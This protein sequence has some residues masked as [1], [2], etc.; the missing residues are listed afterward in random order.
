[1]LTSP[2]GY[3]VVVCRCPC[4]IS[5]H[6]KLPVAHQATRPSPG[7]GSCPNHPYLPSAALAGLHAATDAARPAM[8][9]ALSAGGVAWCGSGNARSSRAGAGWVVSLGGTRLCRCGKALHGAARMFISM[10]WHKCGV[11]SVHHEPCNWHMHQGLG[12]IACILLSSVAA[13][14]RW[15]LIDSIIDRAC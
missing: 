14:V 13:A 15:W 6:R 8:A 11:P 7:Y 10:E 1:L 12:G 2:S 5:F 4:H 3:G 9:V